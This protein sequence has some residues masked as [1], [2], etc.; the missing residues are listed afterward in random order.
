L[1]LKYLV[2]M[3]AMMSRPEEKNFLEF[4]EIVEFFFK[5]WV[6][7]YKH[8]GWQVKR[9]KSK[10]VFYYLFNFSIIR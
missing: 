1:L 8:V 5:S 10:F 9:D 7:G 2:S 6:Y 3:M 4:N